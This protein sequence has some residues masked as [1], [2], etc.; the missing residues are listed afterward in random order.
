M[1]V[2]SATATLLYQPLR[3]FQ[4]GIKYIY[5]LDGA[6]NQIRIVTNQS[7]QDVEKLALSYNKLAKEMNVTTTEIAKT[8]VELY[9]QGLTG[10]AVDERLQGIIKYAKIAGIDMGTSNKIITATMNA[11]GTSAERTIDVMSFL[12]DS[13]AAD[14]AEIGEAMQKTA[15]TAD[16]AGVSYE[17]LGSWISVVSSKTR[18]SAS[19][20]GN[21][22]K[23]IINRYTSIKEQGFNDE[24]AT[25]L[26][27]VTQALNQ[28]GINAIDKQTGG[29]RD[30]SSVMDEL[31]GKYDQLNPKLQAYIST[32]MAG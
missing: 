11:L 1:L 10:G 30:F 20:I 16:A 28:A 27:D 5:E 6:L 22:M 3:Q 7:Q 25:N 26:N 21:S 2:W 15:A 32:T 14:A 31:G 19:T 12:G 24:D 23:S 13:T 8:S 4:A 9:R 18:E 17:K 29:L